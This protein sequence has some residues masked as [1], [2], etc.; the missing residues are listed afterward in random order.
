MEPNAPAADLGPKVQPEK[1][2]N[3]A[4][5]TEQWNAGPDEVQQTGKSDPGVQN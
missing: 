3:P 1:K 2:A 5:Q 4:K